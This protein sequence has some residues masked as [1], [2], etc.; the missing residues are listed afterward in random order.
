MVPLQVPTANGAK[1]IVSPAI[2]HSNANSS[3]N[4]SPL[5]ALPAGNGELRPPLRHHDSLIAEAEALKALLRDAYE[6]VNR[7]L[8]ALK[9]Q[10]QQNKLLASTMS[11][12]RQHQ[13]IDR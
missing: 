10:R 9:R 11:A 13:Q 7:L 4:R 6:R 3:T 5:P 8:T 1:R 12:L 2:H